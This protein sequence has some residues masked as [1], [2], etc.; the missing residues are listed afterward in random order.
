MSHH[1]AGHRRRRGVKLRSKAGTVRLPA[2]ARG[3]RKPWGFAPAGQCRR[4][5]RQTSALLT[6]MPAGNQTCS[7]LGRLGTELR[8]GASLCRAAVFEVGRVRG[9]SRL[10]LAC[11]RG[12]G[13]TAK[14]QCSAPEAGQSQLHKPHPHRMPRSGSWLARF[15][16]QLRAGVVKLCGLADRRLLL[17]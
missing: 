9:V 7:W 13:A 4:S 6:T 5:H 10:V 1:N 12:T 8:C 2:L 17:G 3:F 16:S 15:F 14:K 11:G